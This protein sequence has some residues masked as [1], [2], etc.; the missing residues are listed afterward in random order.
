MLCLLY[1]FFFISVGCPGQLMST[2]I[3]PH[4]SLNTLQTQ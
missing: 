1:D 2:T 4:G 3:I